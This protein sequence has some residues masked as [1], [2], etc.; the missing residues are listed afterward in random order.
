M[1]DCT[2]K[3]LLE[4]CEKLESE[5]DKQVAWGKELAAEIDR[6]KADLDYALGAS[7]AILI[8]ADLQKKDRDLW[9]ERFHTADNL[10]AI[11]KSKVENLARAHQYTTCQCDGFV[12]CPMAKIIAGIEKA[13]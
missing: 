7:R 12:K 6:L 9:K 5:R 10:L 11:E 8:T 13:K 1:S 2:H 3:P 4:Y